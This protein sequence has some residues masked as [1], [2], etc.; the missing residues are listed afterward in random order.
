MGKEVTIEEDREVARPL[1]VL[2]PLIKEDLKRAQEAGMPYYQ[3][4]GEKM[5]EAKDQMVHG[6]FSPWIK[7]HFEVSI[8]QANLYM[9]YA[10][11]QTKNNPRIKF[12]SLKDFRRR[13]L[14]HDI[15]TTGGSIKRPEW[16]ES[17]NENVSRAK[18]AVERLKEESLS[19]EQE[20]KAERQLALRLIDIGYK[21]LVKELHPDKGG[22]REI[23]ARLN[24]VRERLKQC[25]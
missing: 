7:R 5:I 13:G 3:A 24:H 20:R 25:I 15:P 4:A 16:R 9:S 8:Q 10:E 14:G 6:E 19:R 23:M 12:D 18:V 11:S 22:S 2:V 17:V 1:R 21:I